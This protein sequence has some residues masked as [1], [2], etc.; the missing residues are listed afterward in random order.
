MKKIRV[1]LDKK[2]SYDILIGYKIIPRIGS[3]IRKLRLGDDAVVITNPAINLKYKKTILKGLKPSQFHTS[4]ILIKGS[5]TSKSNREVVG[6]IERILKLDRGRG[7]FIAAFGGGMTGDV[8]GFVASIYKRGI[9]YIQVPTTLLAQVD[10][11][12]GGKT[13]IDLPSGKNLIG[14]FYQPRIVVSDIQLLEK[15]NYRIFRSGLGE[16]I[17]Y[18]VIKDKRL[19]EFLEDNI[20]RI[21]KRD[22]D[23]LEYIIYRSSKIKA[24][25]VQADEYDRKGIRAILNYGHTIGHALEA[26]TGYSKLYYHGEAIAIGMAAAA[27]IAEKMGILKKTELRRIISLIKKARLPVRISKRLKIDKIMKAQSYDK[28]IIHGVNR[29]ILPARIGKVGIYENIPKRLIYEVIRNRY[30]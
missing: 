15:L 8:A 26:A 12:I 22:K 18:G 14:A 19:F 11:S 5:E 27:E 21:L 2:R 13:A 7:V 6:L 30:K 4:I 17:K 29:F 25:V 9:P 28:K 3:L 16:I 10:S 20:G 1:R 23:C 24:K